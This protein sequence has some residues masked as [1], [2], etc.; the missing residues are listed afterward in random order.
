M[1]RKYPLSLKSAEFGPLQ[2]L[3]SNIRGEGDFRILREGARPVGCA[4]RYGS[5]RIST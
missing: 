5:R 3:F 4:G 2:N 1:L